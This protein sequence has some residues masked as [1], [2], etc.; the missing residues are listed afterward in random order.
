MKDKVLNSLIEYGPRLTLNINSSK[1]DF[2]MNRDFLEMILNQFESKGFITQV[3]CIGGRI[4]MILNAEIYDFHSHGG[5]TAQEHLLKYNI[6]K[7]LL[8][9]ESLKPSLPD[10][11]NVVTTIASNIA[12]ALG[13]FIHKP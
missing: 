2:N 13:L 3:K 5:F 8:E 6:E 10:K 1:S 9:I 7:L 12:T 11:I 4:D